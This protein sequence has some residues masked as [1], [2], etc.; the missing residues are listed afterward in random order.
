VGDNTITVFMNGL[1]RFTARCIESLYTTIAK[2]FY[3]E[4]AEQK[5]WVQNQ[6]DDHPGRCVAGYRLIRVPRDIFGK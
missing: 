5:Y 2:N 4:R 3:E 1:Q 6:L